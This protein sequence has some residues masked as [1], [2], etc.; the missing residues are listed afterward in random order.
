MA[1]AS[2][3][4][5]STCSTSSSSAPSRSDGAAHLVSGASIDAARYPCPASMASSTAS[6]VAP[7]AAASSGTVGGPAQ[8]LGQRLDRLAQLEVELLDAPGSADGPS[9]VAEVPLQLAHHGAVA[10]VLNSTPRSGSK[11]ST[12]LIRASDATCTRS[13]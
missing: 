8:L 5:S 12:A 10:N 1:G 3:A 11:R 6:S 9:P 13:S 4:R 2:M 7:M